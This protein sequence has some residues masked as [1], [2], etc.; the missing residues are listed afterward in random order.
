MWCVFGQGVE[1][2]QCLCVWILTSV[3]DQISEEAVAHIDENP[4]H[5]V[6]NLHD[7]SILWKT[8]LRRSKIRPLIRGFQLFQRVRLAHSRLSR[9]CVNAKCANACNGFSVTGVSAD[10]HVKHV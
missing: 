10:L 7:L 8:L 1:L 3:E 2:L 6:W 4:S 5:H 9:V